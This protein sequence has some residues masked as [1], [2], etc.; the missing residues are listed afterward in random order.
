MKWRT[1]HGDNLTIMAEMEDETIDL[2]YADP[3][4]A[5][6][7]DFG[8]FDDRWEDGIDGYIDFLFPRLSAMRKLLKPTGSIYLHCDPTASH[9][10]KVALDDLY[11][12]QNFRREIIW[13]MPT[14]S[15]FKTR[16]NNWTRGHD[17][18]LYYT[19]TPAATF[20]KQR[21]PLSQSAISR[22]NKEDEHGKYKTYKD[23]NG[24]RKVY[25]NADRGSCV[26]SVWD[27]IPSFQT[28]SMSKSEGTGYPTQ[29][30]LALLERIIKASSN[31][32]DTVLDPF[33]GSGT[34]GVA[35]VSLGRRWIG[36]DTA[37]LALA[38]THQRLQ[39]GTLL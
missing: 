5:T 25:L 26:S 9:Y 8:T 38:T 2:I 15:G 14:P 12:R 20:N 31:E 28:H 39:Q 37:E 29:K 16:A 33:C 13:R 22:Y 1:E 35:A 18:L 21:L 24:E 23:A 7:R 6:G 30:P 17:T 27:D 11:G 32:G 3:P 4:F 36:I 10:L 19:K 34:S